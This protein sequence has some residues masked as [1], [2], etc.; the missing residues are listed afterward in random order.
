MVALKVY[1]KKTS[2]Q[3]GKISCKSLMGFD[4][5]ENIHIL[6]LMELENENLE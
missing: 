6:V 5:L 2:N 4:C 1:P 3:I